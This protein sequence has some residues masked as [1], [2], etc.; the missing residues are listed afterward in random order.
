MGEEREPEKIY[1]ALHS[2]ALLHGP[3]TNYNSL[4]P[5]TCTGI[6]SEYPLACTLAGSP[7]TLSLLEGEKG[8]P[9]PPMAYHK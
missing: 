7:Y 8:S 1:V 2:K 6:I 4:E 3:L 9:P 5:A